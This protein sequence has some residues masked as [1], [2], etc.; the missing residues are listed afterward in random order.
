[1]ICECPLNWQFLRMFCRFIFDKLYL[2][3]CRFIGKDAK[4]L[5][6]KKALPKPFEVQTGPF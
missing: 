2:I 3:L 5:R 4:K 6:R 1:M